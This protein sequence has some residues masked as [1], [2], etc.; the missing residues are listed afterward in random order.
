LAHLFFPDR[1]AILCAVNPADINQIEGVYP[2]KPTLPAVGGN[3]GVG[4][5]VRVAE[6]YEGGLKPLDWVIPY[7]AGMGT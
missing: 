6:G 4:E 7:S 2:I 5:V 3:E 1:H